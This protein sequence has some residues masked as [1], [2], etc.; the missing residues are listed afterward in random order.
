M[1]YEPPVPEASQSPYPI[2]EAPHVPAPLPPRA[3]SRGTADSKKAGGTKIARIGAAIAIGVGATLAAV[4]ALRHR[5]STA[6]SR[7]AGTGAMRVAKRTVT[8]KPAT[9]PSTQAKQPTPQ[10]SEQA[11]AKASAP[12]KPPAPVEAPGPANSPA[13]VEAKKRVARNT[14]AS[15]ASGRATGKTASLSSPSD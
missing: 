1:Q 6:P 10:A 5:G 14:P 7:P 3:A 2:Q 9:L 8:R 15:S 13:L 12:A 11:S 4:L